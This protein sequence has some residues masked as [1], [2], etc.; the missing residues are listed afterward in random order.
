MKLSPCVFE[1][2]CFCLHLACIH[3]LVWVPRHQMTT[4][5]HPDISSPRPHTHIL[6]LTVRHGIHY[7]SG[8]AH[9]DY[10][11]WG[12]WV[13][14]VLIWMDASHIPH[15]A[16]SQLKWWL[17]AFTLSGELPAIN[18]VTVWW[19]QFQYDFILARRRCWKL[20]RYDDSVFEFSW[21]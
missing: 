18:L 5:I 14:G 10:E 2:V 9:R 12:V 16:A 19:M 13:D 8:V 11:L 20:W 3:L 21:E 6:M 15:A 1:L 7:H 17:C 4:G